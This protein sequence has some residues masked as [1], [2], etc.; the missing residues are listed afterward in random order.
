MRKRTSVANSTLVILSPS[1]RAGGGGGG[2][3]LGWPPA[4]LQGRHFKIFG[5]ENVS[6]PT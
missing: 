1:A 5:E 6:A 3:G 4:H 2:G